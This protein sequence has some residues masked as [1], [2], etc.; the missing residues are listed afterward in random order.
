MIKTLRLLHG[1]EFVVSKDEYGFQKVLE[2]FPNASS[3]H[4]LTYSA[5]TFLKGDLLKA[6]RDL[7]E[8]VQVRIVTNIPSNFQR[9]VGRIRNYVKYLDPS[10]F[11]ASVSI[12]YNCG[13]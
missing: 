11:S 5:S 8:S 13:P 12:F 10:N 7:D 4:I 2:D 1:A 6:L 3:I 9:T